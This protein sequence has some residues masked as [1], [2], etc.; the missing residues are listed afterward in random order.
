MERYIEQ[1]IADIRKATWNMRPPHE[2]WIESKAD[3]DNELELEDMSHVEKYLYG[4]KEPVSVITGIDQNQLPPPEKLTEEQ[5][6]LLAAE[7]ENLLQYFHFY[8]DFPDNY[9]IHLRY[10]FILNFW[11]EEHV[12][13]SFGENHIEFCD[14]EEE[15]CP[16]PGYCNTC[17]E[18]AEEIENDKKID[19]DDGF[20]FDV[21]DLLP[22]PEEIEDWL[23]QQKKNNPAKDSPFSNPFEEGDDDDEE[24]RDEM[25]GF[26]SDDGTKIDTETVPVPGLCIFCKNYLTDDPE[27]NLLCLMTRYDQRNDKSFACGAFEKI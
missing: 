15:N 16:F 17:R 10:P 26:Y 3:P 25:N 20:D 27:E 11:G 9:P 23:Q 7:L 21:A 13:L 18:F 24:Y 14:Y 22:T 2:L 1:L 5:Q 8:L 19:S 6:T 4:E 12:V